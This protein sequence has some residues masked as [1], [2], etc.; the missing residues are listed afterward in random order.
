VTVLTSLS[1][2]ELEGVWGR[3]GVQV[4]DEVVRLATLA[5][6]SGIPGVVA[7][8]KET[9]RIRSALGSDLR[10]LTPGI[11]LA[12]DAAGDQARIATPGDAVRLGS[13]YLVIGRTVTAAADPAAAYDRVLAEL[14]V[15]A[16][17]AIT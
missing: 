13:D 3:D 1:A 9:A 7:S 17:E 8:V 11:R 14:E 16:A 2:R 5:R 12:G 4:E 6:D 15:A 10:I